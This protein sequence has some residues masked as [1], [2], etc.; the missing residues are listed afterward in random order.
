MQAEN[1]E[2]LKQRNAAGKEAAVRRQAENEAKR[3]A[4]PTALQKSKAQFKAA[5]EAASP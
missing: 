5:Q 4:N 2:K 1:L 3:Q